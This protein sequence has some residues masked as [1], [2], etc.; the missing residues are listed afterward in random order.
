MHE[1]LEVIHQHYKPHGVRDST[2]FLFFFPQVT[3]YPGQE[4]RYRDEI[5]EQFELADFLVNALRGRA[6]ENHGAVDEQRITGQAQ[7]SADKG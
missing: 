6:A 2:G 1:R 7:N 5:F 4:R 3:K